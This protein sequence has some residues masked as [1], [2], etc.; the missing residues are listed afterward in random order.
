MVSEP[1]EILLRG[2][3][4]TGDLVMATPGFRAVRGRFPKARITL[5]VRPG[6]EALMH[7]APWFDEVVPVTSYHRGTAAVLREARELRRRAP[8]FDLGICIPDS[9]S[10]ALLMRAGGV[11][12]VAGYRRG[13]RGV[14]LHTP[15]TPPSAWG[16]HRRVAR[17]RFVLDLVGA[18]GCPER[19]THLELFTT[20]VEEK[21][22]AQA[23]SS[24]GVDAARP[25]VALAPGASYGPSKCWPAESFAAVADAVVRAGGQAV[26]VGAPA[27]APLAARVRAATCEPT[28]DLVGALDLGSLKAVLRRASALVCNDAGARHVAVAFGV[29]AIV[30]MG[31]TDLAKTNENLERVTVLQTDVSC[32]PCYRRV[33]PIDHRCMTRIAPERVVAEILRALEPPRSEDGR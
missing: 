33:C 21:R 11:R 2:P 16:S 12:E 18:L 7:G 17:E 28:A 31:P 8:R 14:L 19:G 22:A 6:L 3:N 27:E 10:A 29:P 15:V 25:W 24:R 1:S 13:G 32:R 5:Q 26:L 30:L 9:F 23:L 20:P 4:W